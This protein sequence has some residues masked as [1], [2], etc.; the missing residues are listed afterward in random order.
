MYSGAPNCKFGL[1][2]K[3]KNFNQ[4]TPGP[5]CYDESRTIG[6]AGQPSYSMPGRKKDHITIERQRLGV[7]V[8]GADNYNPVDKQVKKSG[9]SYSIKNGRRDGEINLYK[10]TPGA[11]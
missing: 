5:G 4:T 1:D 2:K 3:S 11:G 9:A 6:A 7:G 8:P 10:N